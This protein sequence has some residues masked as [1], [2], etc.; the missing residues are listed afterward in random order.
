M[1]V[2]RRGSTWAL[3]RCRRY[4]KYREQDRHRARFRFTSAPPAPAADDRARRSGSKGASRVSRA[5][6]YTGSFA[7]LGNALVDYVDWLQVA[8]CR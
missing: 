5:I 3:L 1:R 7:R 8:G 4:P 2:R 6:V